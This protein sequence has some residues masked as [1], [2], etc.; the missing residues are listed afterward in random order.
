M[1]EYS[2]V[3]SI[4]TAVFELAVA[5]YA[6]RAGGRRE[7]LRLVA[8]LLVFLAGYQVIEVFVCHDPEAL[9]WARLAFADVVWLPPLGLALLYRLAQ[10]TRPIWGRVVVGFFAIAAFFTF[11]VFFDDQFVTASVCKA[12]IA[13]YTHPTFALEFYGA[14]YHLGLW[15]MMG[16]GIHLARRAGTELDRDHAADLALG[17]VAFVVLAL[18]TEIVVPAAKEATPSVMCHY[19]ISLAIFL[20]RIARREAMATAARKTSHGDAEARGRTDS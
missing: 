8:A 5:V 9:F 2:P 17:T 12:V 13:F 15:S 4:I 16:A 20:W 19:A 7:V 11:W 1:P 14:F 3:L 6:W 18:T 10:P